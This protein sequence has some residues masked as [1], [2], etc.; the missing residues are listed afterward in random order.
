MMKYYEDPEHKRWDEIAAGIRSEID[1]A[2]QDQAVIG[3]K[4]LEKGWEVSISIDDGAFCSTYQADDMRAIVTTI[5]TQWG[6]G[7]VYE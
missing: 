7:G 4:R 1:P 2:W 6:K 5:R 3:V